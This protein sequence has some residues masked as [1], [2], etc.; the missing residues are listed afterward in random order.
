[1]GRGW[2]TGWREGEGWCVAQLVRGL[3]APR[4]PLCLLLSPSPSAPPPPPLPS[5]RG[6]ATGRAIP[7]FSRV[8]HHPVVLCVG[9]AL[10]VGG[11]SALILLSAGSTA[12]ARRPTHAR[13][14][15]Y[16]PH[17]PSIPCAPRGHCA[18]RAA[19]VREWVAR[20]RDAVR[21]RGTSAVFLL[22]SCMRTCEREVRGRSRRSV[23]MVDV[24]MRVFGSGAA[25]AVIF[26]AWA[27]WSSGGTALPRPQLRVCAGGCRW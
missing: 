10:C 1:M 20:G 4:R 6:R 18:R 17:T 16:R 5:S 19:A 22:A 7:D 11:P 3:A 26:L 15:A 21:G 13:P 8:D 24:G 23:V 12:Q 25:G 27:R 9:G 14:H 2:G